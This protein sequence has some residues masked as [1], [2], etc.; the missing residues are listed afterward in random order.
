V[1]NEGENDYSND[2]TMKLVVALSL[3]V[4]AAV[5]DDNFGDLAIQKT[6]AYYRKMLLILPSLT[7][8]SMPDSV[9]ALRH[10]ISDVRNLLDIFAFAF[11]NNTGPANT[12]VWPKLRGDLDAGYTLIG[13]FQDLDH[14]GVNYTRHDL[15]ERLHKCLAWKKKFE[16]NMPR[17]N[18]EAFAKS[19]RR[20]MLF[21][22]PDR[23]YSKDFWEYIGDSPHMELSGLEN[24]AVLERGIIGQLADNYTRVVSLENIWNVDDHILFHD[25][26]KLFRSAN[27]VHGFFPAVYNTTNDCNVTR[28]VA[29]FDT[30]YNMFGDLNDEVTA[31]QFYIQ[32]HKEKEA[33]QK[34]KAIKKDWAALVA[35][36][37]AEDLPQLFECLN[38]STILG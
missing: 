25:Y 18:Y 7:E 2:H 34:K 10:N 6:P 11:P 27:T 37:K 8:E 12:D 3:L 16:A 32:H 31:Y 22:R 33:A 21:Y 20:D 30:A 35:W 13:D 38:K 29:D 1:R 24:M 4:V 23:L 9:R 28:G 26:R 5:A 17:F 15:E 19:A 14:S 36:M